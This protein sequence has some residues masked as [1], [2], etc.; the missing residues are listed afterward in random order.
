MGTAIV[1]YVVHEFAEFIGI[2]ALFLEIIKGRVFPECHVA[3]RG[4]LVLDKGFS[5]TVFFCYSVQFRHLVRKPA[6]FLM[7]LMDMEMESVY[8]MFIG[9]ESD[10]FSIHVACRV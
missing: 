4:F 10:D 8:Q 5:V 7:R 9:E 1:P 6:I 2:I 3:H